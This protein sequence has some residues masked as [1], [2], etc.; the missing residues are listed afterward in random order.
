[1]WLPLL[2]QVAEHMHL[3]SIISAKGRL[4]KKKNQT[5]TEGKFRHLGNQRQG[6]RQLGQ[7]QDFCVC[8]GM[9]GCV[10]AF[11]AVRSL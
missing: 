11:T 4:G 7:D 10:L 9:G 3:R 5:I 1:M 6:Y 8:P 2:L